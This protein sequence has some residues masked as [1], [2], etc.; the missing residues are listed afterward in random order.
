[1]TKRILLGLL[2]LCAPGAAAADDGDLVPGKV[3]LSTSVDPK[4]D[5]IVVRLDGPAPSIDAMRA[6]VKAVQR[7][8]TA[9]SGSP[10]RG[11]I[12]GYPSAGLL[13]MSV[14]EDGKFATYV[15]NGATLVEDEADFGLVA[16]PIAMTNGYGGWSKDQKVSC[17]GTVRNTSKV[18]TDVQVT[19]DVIGDFS[20]SKLGELRNVTYVTHTMGSTTQALG[21][22]APGASRSYAI[23]V[24]NLT[25]PK[26]K[27]LRTD[28]TTSYG[29]TSMKFATRFTADGA[30]ARHF[31]PIQAREGAAWLALLA[32]ARPTGFALKTT[33]F[34]RGGSPT[35]EVGDAFAALDPAKRKAAALALTAKI[36]AHYQSYL[37]TGLYTV[38]FERNGHPY[39]RI[40]Q[41]EYKESP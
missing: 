21:K 11:V 16:T 12:V 1:M 19:C 25:S 30:A 4:L 9:S 26:D 32:A 17:T 2:V 18:A 13:A 7:R 31:D 29:F 28:F 27:A 20:V 38:Y 34:R 37:D 41:S 24:T 23:T 22:L 33:G 39:A 36:G 14:H 6:E 40:E 35:F 5:A 3:V 15:G 10:T 8:V